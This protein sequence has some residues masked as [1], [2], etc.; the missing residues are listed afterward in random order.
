MHGHRP[1]MTFHTVLLLRNTVQHVFFFP[2]YNN[3]CYRSLTPLVLLLFGRRL[4]GPL[5]YAVLS[6][7][8]VSLRCVPYVPMRFVVLLLALHNLSV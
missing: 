2:C 7:G 4:C 1:W 5:Y 8:L 3:H 6:I